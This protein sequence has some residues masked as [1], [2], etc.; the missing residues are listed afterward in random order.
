M[1]IVL[2]K[3]C[4]ITYFEYDDRIINF[5]KVHNIKYYIGDDGDIYFGN[6]S[7]IMNVF[8]HG[9]IEVFVELS[10]IVKEQN[11]LR[12]DSE[13][14]YYEYFSELIFPFGNLEMIKFLQSRTDLSK[15]PMSCFEMLGYR[16]D[17]NVEIVD[18]VLSK[19][20]ISNN[21]YLKIVSNAVEVNNIN[22][23]QYVYN[24]IHVD[25]S[26]LIKNN[27]IRN[28]L[29][30]EFLEFFLSKS[31]LSEKDI[32]DG[33]IID[34]KDKIYLILSYVESGR[35]KLSNQTIRLLDEALNKN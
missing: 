2:E 7:F 20:K 31:L 19:L 4:N 24:M 12:F 8:L 11:Y 6:K 29:N 25:S 14:G 33:I 34:E 30:I 1:D 35:L 16:L 10:D 26:E 5:L 3:F 15:L 32:V 22:I 17:D 27:V 13:F 23:F 28:E 21:T 18:A 9:D